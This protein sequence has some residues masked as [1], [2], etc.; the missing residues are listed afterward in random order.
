MVNRRANPLGESAR[1]QKGMAPKQGD[2]PRVEK[3]ACLSSR[4]PTRL[5]KCMAP[6]QSDGPR[7]EKLEG[8]VP[9]LQVAHKTDGDGVLGGVGGVGG[10]LHHV[11]QPHVVVVE[12]AAPP[13]SPPP[14]LLLPSCSTGEEV[15]V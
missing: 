14:W 9:V 2:G 8:R 10:V 11:V 15:L 1:P 5:Q 13:S 4:S 12:P 7:V 6:K 3:G